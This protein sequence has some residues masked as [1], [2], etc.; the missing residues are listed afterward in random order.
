MKSDK[1]LLLLNS[2]ELVKTKSLRHIEKGIIIEYQYNF[3]LP[4]GNSNFVPIWLESDLLVR[5][6]VQSK[7]FKR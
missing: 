6:V 1:K 7:G 4:L 2:I 3:G 5:T